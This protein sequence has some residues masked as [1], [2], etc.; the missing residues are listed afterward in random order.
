MGKLRRPEAMIFDM[1]GTLFR[2]ETLVLPAF[3]RTFERLCEEGLHAGGM[4]PERLILGSLGML[5]AHIWERVL[6]DASPE[7]R[8]RADEL[9]L[10]CELEGLAAGGG[11]LYEGVGETLGELNR[12][13]VRLFVASN[14][15]EA[16]VRQVAAAKGL[17]GLFEGIYS[18]GE[19]ATRTKAELVRLLMERHG[20]EYAWMVGDRSSDVQAG[21]E[22]GI[23]VIGC[24]YAGFGDIRELKGADALIGDFRE[25]LGLYEQAR[26]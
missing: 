12:R 2:S 15:L 24:R 5:L 22:N 14:G 21:K 10:E 9:F 25:I 11:E 16:Y 23:P 1:D 19:Y 8:R 20:L 17:S 6:P 18:A 7:V 4:P 3:R 13:G 26:A